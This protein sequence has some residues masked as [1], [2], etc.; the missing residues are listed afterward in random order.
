MD[1]NVCGAPVTHLCAGC[2]IARYCSVECADADW[3]DDHALWCF[4][5]E[6]PDHT[7]LE[8]LVDACLTRREEDG[9]D[10]FSDVDDAIEWLEAELEDPHE[11]GKLVEKA[12]LRYQKG[13]KTLG[14]IKQKKGKLQ[15][16]RGERLIKKGDK[17]K[18]DRLVRKGEK[19][20][21]SGRRQKKRARR[22]LRRIRRR[23]RRRRRKRKK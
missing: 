15:Q 12:K 2:Q 11:I 8:M 18:G 23:K 17:E 19:A 21:E 7:H 4:D 3:D 20:E 14:K 9:E 10:E 6:N 13:K 1:C 22:K 5:R 16:R